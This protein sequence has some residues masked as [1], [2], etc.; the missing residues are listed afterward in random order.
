M[1]IMKW[2]LRR[3]F[4]EH[5]SALLWTPAVLGSI[6]LAIVVL[7]LAVPFATEHRNQMHMRFGDTEILNMQDA[8]LA[9]NE[10]ERLEQVAHGLSAIFLAAATPISLSLSFVVFFYFLGSLYEER[11]NRSVLFW[12]SLPVSDRDTVLSKLATGLLLAPLI[13]WFIALCVSVVMLLMVV[14][15][16]QIIGTNV[17]A[18]VFTN[19]RT[20][21][22]PFEYL[23]LLPLYVLWALPTAGWLCL[24]SAWARSRPILWALGVPLFSGALLAWAKAMFGLPIDVAWYMRQVVARLLL[25]ASPGSWALDEGL[26]FR[27]G[28]GDHDGAAGGAMGTPL[29]AWDLISAPGLWLGVAAGVAMLALAIRLRRYRDEA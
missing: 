26:R 10:P 22:L 12:K 20:Y 25:G 8:A 2:L 16:L 27:V 24:V 17:F 23:G 14:I 15:A 11:N 6:M 9:L 21:T 18:A 5:K 28:F 3:E 1:N 4:W 7:S 19:P 13:S 29:A